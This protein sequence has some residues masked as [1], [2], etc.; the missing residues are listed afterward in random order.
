MDTHTPESFH[1]LLLRHRGRTGLIQ[2]DLAARAGVSVRSVQDWEAGV[3]FPSAERLQV[4]IGALFAAGSLTT[5]RETSEARELWTAVEREAP[6]MHTPFDQEWVAGL[7]AAPASPT[8]TPPSDALH[9][10]RAAEPGPGTAE[11]A[12]DWGEPPA[13]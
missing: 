7:L 8:R 3:K 1:G 9:N 6:R 12:Q 13:T 11:R 2:R 10:V 5:G 4:L